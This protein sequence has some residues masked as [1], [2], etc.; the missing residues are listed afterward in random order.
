MRYLV[1]S[2]DG[3]LLAALGFGACAWQIRLPIGFWWAKPKAVANWKNNATK[4][5]HLNKSGSIPYTLTSAKSFALNAPSPPGLP[6]VYWG[7]TP[8]AFT[9]ISN[10]LRRSHVPIPGELPWLIP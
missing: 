6:N 2:A 1:R 3:R 4:F 5:V 7:F 9:K 8:I 10:S